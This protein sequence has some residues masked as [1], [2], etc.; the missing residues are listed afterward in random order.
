MTSLTREKKVLLD[1][2]S[3]DFFLLDGLDNQ[4]PLTQSLLA[5]NHV[6][7]EGTLEVDLKK[8]ERFITVLLGLQKEVYESISE[9]VGRKKAN[10]RCQPSQVPRDQSVFQR[11]Q[12]LAGRQRQKCS[13]LSEAC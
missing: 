13:R 9:S 3:K 2:D 10:L 11:V 7:Q 6:L 8:A 5:K 12:K 4:E 1:E